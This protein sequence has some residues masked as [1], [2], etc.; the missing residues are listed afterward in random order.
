MIIKV[1]SYRLHL[2][3]D[4]GEMIQQKLPYKE[5]KQNKK[6]KRDNAIQHKNLR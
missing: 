4:K 5:G 2:M 6:Y 3:F 1:I